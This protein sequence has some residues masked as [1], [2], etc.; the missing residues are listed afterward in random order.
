MTTSAHTQSAHGQAPNVALLVVLALLLLAPMGALSLSPW[1]ANSSF[2]YLGML[3]TVIGLFSS[4]RLGFAAAFV[5]PTVM[6]LSLLLRDLP[7]VGAVFMAALGIATGFSAMRGWHLMAS[8]AGPLAAFALIGDLQVTLPSGTVSADSSFGSGLVVVGVVLVGGLWTAFIGRFVV[9]MVHM[10]PPKKFAFHTAG[11]YAAALGILI[12]VASYIA[13]RWLDP[14]SWWMIL[15]FYV[16]VQ[17]YYADAAKRVAARVI[18]TLAGALLAVV[19]VTL[20]QDQPA[21]ITILAL[22]LTVAA[23]WANMKLPYWAF[24]TFLTPA[25][26]LQ[27]TGGSEAIEKS[28]AER[29]A[30]TLIGAAAAIVVLTIGHFFIERFPSH[31]DIHEYEHSDRDGR[32]RA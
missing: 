31:R 32:T 18:G 11:Y 12:G 25:V 4:A 1:Q 16:V 5:T 20:L 15:T 13:M 23:A 17:P 2:W 26:V 28:I 3:P 19:I 24:V 21:I 10:K 27:T 22:V 6:G 30:Y 14:D 8:F 7:T 29:A 9:R